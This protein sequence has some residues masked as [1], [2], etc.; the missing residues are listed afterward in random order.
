V[1]SCR[2]PDARRVTLVATVLNEAHSLPQLLKSIQTQT[3]PPD[4]IVLVDGG[5][6]DGTFPQLQ[7]WARGRGDV[8]VL[9]ATGANIAQGRNRAIERATGE[10]VA[11]TDAGVALEPDWL[12]HLV[13]ALERDPTA[14]VAAGFFVP[15]GQTLF[16]RVMGAT[17]LPA[18]E[19]V[20]PDQ[21]L[22]SSRSVAFLRSA[23]ERAGGYPEWLDYCEDVVF[24][25]MLQDAGYRFVFAPEAVVR[26]RPRG[27]LPA[28]FRQYYQYARGDGKAGLWP[29]RHAIRYGT[30]LVG[31]PM[32]W[33]GRRQRWLIAMAISGAAAYVRRPVQRWLEA[34]AAAGD[35]WSHVMAGLALIPLIRLVGDV[36]KML[37]YPVGVRWRHRSRPIRW[38]S[39]A[40]HDLTRVELAPAELDLSVVIVS[41]NTRELLRRCLASLERSE[42]LGSHE[43]Y[44]VDNA[45]VDGSP[46]M[47]KGEF[48]QVR[49]VCSAVNGG[50]AYG[51]NL[52]LRQARGR[53]IL[54]LNPDTEV[55]PTAIAEMVRYLDAH[56][57]AA[58]VGPKLVRPDGT[59]D[60]AARRSIPT[61]AVAF[62]RLSGLSRVFPHSQRFGRYNL[63]YL[64]PDQESEVD[65][66]AGAFMLLRREAIEEVGLLDERFFM[67]GEDMDWAYR[68]ARRGWRILYNPRVTVLHHKGASSRQHSHRMTWEFY[69]SMHLFYH[70]HFRQSMPPV[71]DWLV[72]A[73]IYARFAW[74]L[75]KNALRPAEERRVST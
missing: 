44:V 49:L 10:I 22:P 5:S 59:L 9:Q 65:V 15:D 32:L 38:T 52:A 4:E 35:H 36:A 45:S 3:R 20:A 26:F 74:S 25:R 17:V 23:W 57:K 53:R 42:E 72:I 37:G 64:D 39:R 46:A 51:N 19:D 71:I 63:T 48:P 69:R 30:Y 55:K 1:Y 31:L 34:S 2:M 54:L 66:L 24:D 21:F 62:Y 18:R 73:G 40:D 16:E 28:F 11:V 41:Y 58:A 68:V 12:E 6:T 33:R 13:G 60:L 47:V 75:V 70:K 29:R 56:P 8:Q 67:Y 7:Q 50:Y 61:P 14:A 43:V 27:S